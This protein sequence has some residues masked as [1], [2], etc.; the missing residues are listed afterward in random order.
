MFKENP[1]DKRFNPS[2]NVLVSVKCLYLKIFLYKIIV[3]GD[4]IPK[5]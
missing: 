1:F 3:T 4:D 5:V 2:V